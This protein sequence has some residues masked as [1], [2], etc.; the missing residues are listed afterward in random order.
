MLRKKVVGFEPDAGTTQMV[1]SGLNPL[2][3]GFLKVTVDDSVA[4]IY[5]RRVVKVDDLRKWL[6]MRSWS[7]HGYKTSSAD[8]SRSCSG[9]S[10]FYFSIN[11]RLRF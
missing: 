11:Q 6:I 10:P 9:L 2:M 5:K 3:T 1:G 7:S 8:A 4:M